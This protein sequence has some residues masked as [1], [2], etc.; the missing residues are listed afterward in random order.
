MDDALP[1]VYKAYNMKK[2]NKMAEAFESWAERLAE[3]TWALPETDDEVREL[4]DLMKQPLPAGIDAENASSALYN[5]IGD[6]ELF[7]ELLDLA[8][9]D[10][11]QD[12]R[13]AVFGWLEDNH[14]EL[15]EKVSAA[16]DETEP[17]AEMSDTGDSPFDSMSRSDLLDYLNV[18][19]L[20]AQN[21]SN[22]ELRASAE[23]KSQ[24]MTEGNQYGSY[25]EVY[26][27]EYDKDQ[28]ESIQSAIIRRILGNIG[29]HSELLK[30]AGPDGVMNA[31]H[32]VASFHAPVEELGSSDISAMVREVYNEIGVEY[33][34]LGE[35]YKPRDEKPLTYKKE[36]PSK[37][38]QNAKYYDYLARTLGEDYD[39]KAPSD[40]SSPLTYAQDEEL[41]EGRVKEVAMDLEELTDE[42]FQAKYSKT[43]QEM[44][45]AL[46]ENVGDD[47]VNKDVKMKRMGAKPLGM[48]DKLK[49]I[50][51]GI[52]AM[53][54]GDSED[55]LVLYNKQFD[56]DIAQMRRIA[57]L[58]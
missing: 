14:P 53:A 57:G 7:D 48:L 4:I 30:K 46:A 56:E 5:L 26:E 40:S 10:P 31:A 58:K 41:E 32:D 13:P 19:P 2:T 37:K 34:E 17:V 21:M 15:A 50:P 55:D 24:D 49:T 22:E 45:Q 52:K 39:A 54:K 36:A 51:Q 29:Q 43:K 9:D 27:M 23:E 8:K 11:E 44:Q 6:D 16:V 25:G 33:P 28:V 3:G 12:I 38:R 18:S 1:I 42:E 20:D 47:H 35:E